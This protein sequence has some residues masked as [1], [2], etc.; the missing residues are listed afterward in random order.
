MEILRGEQKMPR[1]DKVGR[2]EFNKTT[3]AAVIGA[4]TGTG[5]FGWGVYSLTNDDEDSGSETQEITRASYDREQL[6]DLQ[7]CLDESELRGLGESIDELLDPDQGRTVK[8]VEIVYDP[9][10]QPGDTGSSFRYTVELEG[11]GEEHQ[12]GWYDA[13]NKVLE[14]LAEA[15]EYNDLSNYAEENCQ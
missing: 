15:S 8:E 5:G 3:A 4:L 14:P 2:R 11:T 10:G 9:N 1:K 12:L 6:T 7:A 13:Q